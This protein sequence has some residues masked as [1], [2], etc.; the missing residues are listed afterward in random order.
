MLPC[1][2]CVLVAAADCI[3]LTCI[4]FGF[5]PPYSPPGS[6]VIAATACGW[7]HDPC[8]PP[9]FLCGSL[10]P[11]LWRALLLDLRNAGSL[12]PL[13]PLLGLACFTTSLISLG[14]FCFFFPGCK[15]ACGNDVGRAVMFAAEM[16]PPPEPTTLPASLG[17]RLEELEHRQQEFNTQLMEHVSSSF[18]NVTQQLSSLARSTELRR[19]EPVRALAA[20]DVA[21]AYGYPPLL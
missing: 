18:D 8:D 5:L 14:L 21:E 16:A 17:S 19:A 9:P 13:S 4:A 1:L 6:V 3:R 7:S 15:Q 2:L 20:V 11:E 12:L 10:D